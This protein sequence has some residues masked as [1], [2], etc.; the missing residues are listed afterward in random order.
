MKT[1]LLLGI[2]IIAVPLFTT[3]Q[4]WKNTP[5][6]ADPGSGKV[7]QLQ[8]N[9]SDDFNYN[10]KNAKFRKNWKDGYFN[11]WRG[12]GLT[13]WQSNH[14]DVTGGNL[15]IRASRNGARNVNCGVV[16]SKTKVI[17]P[18]FMEARI[19]VSNL[20][21]SSNFWMLS[22]DDKREIDVLEVYGGAKQTWFAQRMSTNFHVFI[23]G[24]NNQILADYNDQ[25]H[26]TLPNNEPWRNRFHTFGVYWKSPSEVYFYIDGKQTKEGSWAQSRMFAKNYNPQVM[27]KNRYNMD[28][29]VFMIIDT[30]DH[31][32]RSNQ[33]IVANDA[34]LANPAKNKMLVDWVRTYKPVNGTT[35]PKPDPKPDPTPTP[36]ANAKPSVSFDKLNN[37]SSFNAGVDL[38]VTVN[39]SDSDGIANVKLYLNNTLV[40]QENVAPYEWGQANAD[41]ILKK[42]RAGRYTLKAVAT[43]KKG[44]TNETSITITVTDKVIPPA[45][46]DPVIPVDPDPV[47]PTTQ[48]I[49]DGL[50][51]I[52]NP[53]SNQRILSRAL[54][55]YN[56]LMVDYGNYTDQQWQITHLGNNVYTIKNSR[57]NR[58]LEVPNGECKNAANVATWTNN[59]GDH[60]KWAATSNGKYF[61]FKPLHCQEQ[62]LDRAGGLVDANL[63]TWEYNASN[64]NQQWELL[65]T[66]RGLKNIND[67]S[68]FAVYPNPVSKE[69][70][71]TIE[72][73]TPN[74]IVNI[75][76]ALGQL[77]K[78]T[79]TKNDINEINLTG[80]SNGI[81]FIQNNN[82][83]FKLIVK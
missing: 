72:N 59:A 12:P 57:N 47:V 37:N 27:D 13:R 20:E 25:N 55:N 7:W 71:L 21:L 9:Y 78:S 4:D 62:A 32:W 53:F 58:Y 46:V 63:I 60:K 15:V 61:T 6:P 82:R 39:A 29:P 19:K 41:G 2:A 10:G 68:D 67:S 76:N 70:I 43:D 49:T 14:S 77:I 54:E 31:A 3:A 75:Y 73:T 74:S 38:K 51:S 80:F 24:N 45:P 66:S 18:I 40:R 17:Y 23:R 81:Y 22:Q 83:T 26:V 33:G 35:P 1:N 64:K 48:L 52:K 65:K 8:E 5:V 50:Y 16:T 36:V 69:S 11:A 44:A 30:E 79:E 56:A 42:I 34:D 28:R